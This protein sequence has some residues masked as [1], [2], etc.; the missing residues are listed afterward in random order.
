MKKIFSAMICAVVMLTSACTK[1]FDASVNS[2]VPMKTITLSVSHELPEVFGENGTRVAINDKNQLIWEVDDVVAVVY[3][4]NGTLSRA[5]SEALKAGDSAVGQPIYESAEFSVSIPEDATVHYA[6]SSKCLVDEISASQLRPRMTVPEGLTSRT[7]NTYGASLDFGQVIREGFA[8]GAVDTANNKVTLRN[9]TAFFEVQLTGA[10]EVWSVNVL[11]KSQNLRSLYG[12]VYNP[13]SEN[14]TLGSY[15]THQATHEDPSAMGGIH[16][17]MPSAQVQLSSTPKSIYFIMPVVDLPAGDLFLQIRTD[18]YT[19]LIRSK[20]AHSFKRNHVTRLKP[21]EVASLDLDSHTYE[22]LD[23]DGLSNCYMV[24]PSN[25]DKYYSFSVLTPAGR[26]E[27]WNGSTKCYGVWPMWATKDYLIEDLSVVYT[28]D[29]G[30]DARVYFKVPAGSGKGSCVLTGGP[31]N[32]T[33]IGTNWTWHIWVTDAQAQ[34]FGE[35]A[36][37]VLD[38]APGALWTPTSLDDV[39]AMT[40]ETAAQT[41]GFMYQ[42]GRHVPFPGPKNISDPSLANKWGY[43]GPGGSDSQAR[44]KQNMQHV[45][46]YHFARWQN[47]FTIYNSADKNVWGSVNEK[48]GYQE[49][50]TKYYNMQ[51][52]WNNGTWASDVTQEALNADGITGN[53]ELWSTAQKGNQDPCP[54]GYRVIGVTEIDRLYRNIT[55]DKTNKVYWEQ[56]SPGKQARVQLDNKK[57]ADPLG[58]FVDGKRGSGTEAE[59]LKLLNGNFLWFPHGGLRMGTSSKSTTSGSER[60]ETGTLLYSTNY[61]H[62]GDAVLRPGIGIIWGVFDYE[63]TPKDD[64]LK[65]TTTFVPVHSISSYANYVCC[66]FKWAVS[67]QNMWVY[68]SAL[69]S[70][71]DFYNQE[72]ATPVSGSG[73]LPA[74]DAAPVRCVK[75]AT[76]SGEAQ[77]S[78]LAGQQTDA[79]AWN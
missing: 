72:G 7:G 29:S 43:E 79:N 76:A 67:G 52:L 60:G 46:Y 11:S 70:L 73:G 48:T 9:A 58:S 61:Y 15:Q 56:W 16:F 44:F 53:V 69:T 5:T 26:N 57:A 8:T 64:L 62:D 3:T 10:D 32:S 18:K 37:T 27:L 42:Y 54:Q 33:L 34:T 38:R 1:D 2:N 66:P 12:Y 68:S 47:G 78:S 45:E 63:G 75:I 28:T 51:M 49:N 74:H 23:A 6:Y 31:I 39:K 17:N 35:P 21:I 40:G 4:S 22:P 65:K 20:A 25:E 36:V 71:I 77:V 19:R 50:G 41:V 30:S 24:T 13:A 59:H 14:P 55:A